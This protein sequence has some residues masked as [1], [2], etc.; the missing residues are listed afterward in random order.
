MKDQRLGDRGSFLGI[1]GQRLGYG[2][3]NQES[4]EYKWQDWG[5][6]KHSFRKHSKSKVFWVWGSGE[7][8]YRAGVWGKGLGAIWGYYP[9]WKY[10]PPVPCMMTSVTSTHTVT[11]QR[12]YED[13]GTCVLLFSQ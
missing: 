1:K 2:V 4:L 7:R 5:F 6:R 13:H 9:T 3:R 11:S 12:R 10:Y 8:G